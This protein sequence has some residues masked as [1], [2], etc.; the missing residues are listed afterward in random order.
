MPFWNSEQEPQR[1]PQLVTSEN[2]AISAFENG[3]VL[4][5]H[6]VIKADVVQEVGQLAPILSTYSIRVM[7][8]WRL[9]F[10]FENGDVFDVDLEDYHGR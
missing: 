6:S 10:R 2:P 7:G 4:S 3:Q 8:N 1:N 9:T 5:G